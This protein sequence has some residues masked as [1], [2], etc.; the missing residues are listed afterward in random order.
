M[1]NILGIAMSGLS[2][3]NLT[4]AGTTATITSGLIKSNRLIHIF[5]KAGQALES[6][7]LKKK[8][9]KLFRMWLINL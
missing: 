2:P 4:R 1:A 7:V 9:L 5:G 8:H 3:S 6:L